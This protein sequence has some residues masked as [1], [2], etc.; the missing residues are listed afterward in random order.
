MSATTVPIGPH[1]GVR[2]AQG[3]FATVYRVD[4]HPCGPVAL[5]WADTDA[6]EM[7]RR[8]LVDEFAILS[9]F[10]YPFFPGAHE[11][12]WCDGRPFMIT[13]WFGGETLAA[14]MSGPAPMGFADVLRQAA[15]LLW[16]LHRRGWVHGDL[17]PENLI[18][19]GAP[20]T[21]HGAGTETPPTGCLRLLDF[22]LTRRAGD[23]D[24][25]R[26]AGTIGYCAPEFLNREP[27]DGRADWYAMGVILYE[28]AYG[29]RP[30]AADEPALEI[31]GHLENEPDFSRRPIRAV[32]T[33]A[34]EVIGRLLQKAPDAR[35]ADEEKLLEWLAEFDPAVDPDRLWNS[36][37]NWH[38]RSEDRRLDDREQE[39]V[40][41]ITG[42]ILR[43]DV[44]RWS[45]GTHGDPPTRL[46]RHLASVLTRAGLPVNIGENSET[47]TSEDQGCEPRSWTPITVCGNDD[48]GHDVAVEF[49]AAPHLSTVH[50]TSGQSSKASGTINFLPWDV[51]RV[52]D[53]LAGVT[54]DTEFAE[55]QAG[56]LF[57]RTGGMPGAVSACMQYLI[58]HKH[59]RRESGTWVLDASGFESWS[60]TEK[61]QDSFAV[62][63]GDLNKKE[64]RLCHWL[65]LGR[66]HG[67]R[68]TLEELSED[69]PASFA[70]TFDRLV[71]RGV[72]VF[73]PGEG[74]TG[75]DVRLR[76]P[77]W[78]DV[79]L[80]S[81]ADSEHSAPKESGALR[82]DARLLAEMIESRQDASTATRSL[83]LY[84]CWADAGDWE[85]AA[86]YALQMASVDMASER[87]DA[88]TGRIED[89]GEAASKIA[90]AA[91]RAY[92]TGQARLALGDLHKA[93]GRLDSARDIYRDLLRLGR[94]TADTRLLAETLKNLGD[95]YRIARKFDKG[96]RTLRMAR[97]LFESLGDRAEAARTIVNIG[98]LYWVA[99]D[100]DAARR[101]YEQGLDIHRA[102]GADDAAAG[103]L[104]N[105][106]ALHL[107]Q[108]RYGEAEACFRDAFAVHDRLDV[109]VEKAR[110]LNN[111]GAIKF[112]T[113]MM[114]EARDFFDRAAAL[115]A[116]ADA[117]SE[118]VFNR[119]NLI[120]VA[121]ECGDLRTVVTDGENVRRAAA[122]LGD[123][124]T[125]ADVGALLAEAFLRAGDFR[126]ARTHLDAVSTASRDLTDQDL[127]VHLGIVSASY[128]RRLGR[129][130]EALAILDGLTAGSGTISNRHRQFDV[131]IVRMHV[132]VQQ[133]D[134]ER[135][136][137]LWRDGLAEAEAIGAPHLAAQLAF[138]QLPGD[139][140]EGFAED[141]F[142]RVEEFLADGRPWHWAPEFHIWCAHRAVG[143]QAW[144]TAETAVDRAIVQ[145]RNDGNWE[146]LWRALA[147]RG[148]IAT[149][150]ADYEPALRAFK[151]AGRVL[152]AIGRTID[153]RAD[154]DAYGAHPLA[155]D[156]LKRRARIMELV[157]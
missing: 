127:R 44:T 109:S 107:V 119:R 108:Y 34:P 4:D 84:S 100:W 146:A 102:L 136:A 21:A 91:R 66:S 103:T 61:A 111:L 70:R 28:W 98:N 101:H 80:R 7:I 156:M 92:W 51:D 6:D 68:A 145:L 141:A 93:T 133:G 151:E 31:A 126:M 104:T 49:C 97:R 15:R 69:D 40:R 129:N 48:A 139:P 112:M 41:T 57:H 37:L 95:L 81:L 130:S 56:S 59:L 52:A 1:R 14:Q 142:R 147:V 115:N 105:L 125:A 135:V 17:K 152:E 2:V 32:P 9:E 50:S 47:V 114:V 79:L 43:H 38:R 74:D 144:D 27:A 29:V 54:G 73:A 132:A 106:G 150:Q 86:A 148:R 22:G 85:K 117:R 122:A 76:L 88:A 71:Q 26:G 140:A 12:G 35:A 42:A 20:N 18:C 90:D 137:T 110:T 155:C 157:G 11:I 94:R 83:V 30:F 24:R 99:A 143:Q 113:G 154:R 82:T 89:A 8:S 23:S 10:D 87:S 36:D 134:A 124:A 77:G 55:R 149:E 153:D 123:V 78:S 58:T 67:H 72:I 138:A 64:Q 19:D 62:V 13:D 63:M 121:L 39:T 65:A 131:N 96:A 33:W 25:P 46:A 118:A 5:K 120:E 16:F 116:G 128:A 53:Y 45:I 3:G 60:E 75:F